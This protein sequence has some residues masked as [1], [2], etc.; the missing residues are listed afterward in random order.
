[1]ESYDIW[2]DPGTHL[3]LNK[4]I[5]INNDIDVNKVG[6]YTVSYTFNDENNSEILERKVNVVYS[7]DSYIH[8]Y[9]G[10]G[11]LNYPYFDFYYSPDDAEINKINNLYLDY[12]KKY[13]FFRTNIGENDID[14][15]FYISNSGHKKDSDSNIIVEHS[16]NDLNNGIIGE[17]YITLKFNSPVN[18]IK[19]YSIKHSFMSGDL[20]VSF[21]KKNVLYLY[22]K[23]YEKSV[24]LLKKYRE[25]EYEIH[26]IEVVNEVKNNSQLLNNVNE[27]KNKIDYF[28]ETF[29]IKYVVLFGDYEEITSK[30]LIP[31]FAYEDGILIGETKTLKNTKTHYA[32][33][34]VWYG[35]YPKIENVDSKNEI[36]LFNKIIIGR[37]SP[38]DK[39]YYNNTEIFDDYTKIENVENQVNKIIKYENNINKYI[40]NET[41]ELWMKKVVSLGSNEGGYPDFNGL[42][43]LS[44]GE[45]LRFEVERYRKNNFIYSEFYDD[46]IPLSIGNV[47]EGENI[48]NDEIGNLL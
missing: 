45:Y 14:N 43:N 29:N 36:F 8:I 40:L 15:P 42:D 41:S 12:T 35:I 23:K 18:N 22:N 3:N 10:K 5:I 21:N 34:D 39:S 26:T 33:S 1:M 20:N 31:T 13:K 11:Q 27:I 47:K 25:N 28:F 46:Y 32:A 48:E 7:N 44:D 30:Q 24:E 2:K 38:G 4:E 6:E 9:V 19:Y 17:Q 16:S 37:I